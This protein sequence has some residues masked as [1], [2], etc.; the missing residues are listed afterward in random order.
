MSSR[1]K[2]VGSGLV[3]AV[4]ALAAWL[5]LPM[6]NPV[7]HV[8]FGLTSTSTTRT[9]ITNGGHFV[10]VSVTNET[11]VAM[12]LSALTVQQ[13]SRNGQMVEQKA[14][15]GNGQHPGVRLPPHG[16]AELPVGVAGEAK[17]FRVVFW[18][19]QE[20][21][22]V[23]KAISRQVQKLPVKQFPT[24]VS[25]WLSDVGLMD[26]NERGQHTSPWMPNPFETPEGRSGQ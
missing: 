3:I 13:E 5:A 9:A 8:A 16:V 17:R 10:I 22:P 6:A 4:L 2:I 11:S 19:F 21:G 26:G 24:S 1:T 18:W 15:D 12:V 14:L 25:L 23:R 20:A 7:P